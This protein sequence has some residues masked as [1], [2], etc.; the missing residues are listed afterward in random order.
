MAWVPCSPREQPRYAP[1]RL[2]C[3]PPSSRQ[4]LLRTLHRAAVPSDQV[5]LLLP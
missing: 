4:R 5:Q 3:L 1:L 2:T